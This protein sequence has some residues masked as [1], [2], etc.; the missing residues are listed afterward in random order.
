MHIYFSGIG[1]S[2]L[3]AMANLCIDL[4]YKV[5]GSDLEE[6]EST[7]N[8]Q[9]RGATIFTSQS[10]QNLET[11]N[12]IELID[13]FVHTPAVRENNPEYQFCVKNNIKIS[14]Q[15]GLINYI[16]KDK[17]LKL[18][19]VAGT[20]GKTTTTAMVVW[21]IKELKQPVS[22]VI[23]SNVSFGNSG[24]YEK[25]S[26]YLIYEADEYDRKFLELVPDITIISSLDFDHP[27]TYVNLYD[28]NSAF[29]KFLSQTK[30]L[31]CIWNEDFKKLGVEKLETDAKLYNPD[32]AESL[33]SEYLSKIKL[34]GNHN[35]KNAF[36]AISAV[37][38]VANVDS[39][40]LNDFIGTFPGTQRRM[41]KLLD[42][43]YSDYAHHTTEIEAVLESAAELRI[44][45]NYHQIVVVYQ[46]HQ[47]IRQ[48]SMLS[49]YADCFKGADQVYWLPTYLSRENP[50]LKVLTPLEIVASI[51]QPEK[52]D[53]VDLD[54]ELYNIVKKHL[55]DH[56][57]VL[58]LGAGSIDNWFRKYFLIS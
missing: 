24:A 15:N 7:L 23:G 22:W 43:L 31:V 20:H 57:L 27:D 45:E 56:D 42:G 38:S 51:N 13:W 3:S 39:A 32:S 16:V 5:S 8:L 55:A 4:G 52:I 53:I 6:N 30:Q 37:S 26:R 1:G 40:K 14:K 28:Y 48:H 9:K 11:Q 36:L 17:G 58:F 54:D 46:P 49:K 41:E 25:D 29:A 35:R 18:F 19:A 50:N 21:L 33:N 44:K 34:T 2:G 12:N 10:F 47:N